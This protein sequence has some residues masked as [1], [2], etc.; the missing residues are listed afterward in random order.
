MELSGMGRNLCWA[1]QQGPGDA[2]PFLRGCGEEPGPQ[3]AGTTLTVREVRTSLSS[4]RPLF[5][6]GKLSLGGVV[7]A[8]APS[9]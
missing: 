5:T 4:Q 2:G 7:A 1:A 3:R 8:V 9:A 6:V